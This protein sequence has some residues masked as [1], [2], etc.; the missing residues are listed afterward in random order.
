[1][2][3][4]APWTLPVAWWV[5]LLPLTTLDWRSSTAHVSGRCCLQSERLVWVSPTRHL[6]TIR[7][8]LWECRLPRLSIML[9]RRMRRTMILIPCLLAAIRSL[10][11]SIFW[12]SERF[13]SWRNWTVWIVW[14]VRWRRTGSIQWTILLTSCRFVEDCSICV[15]VESFIFFSAMALEFLSKKKWNPSNI[16]VF[17]QWK[18][19]HQ[20]REQVWL[21]EQ[22]LEKEKKK[23]EELK[24]QLQEERKQDEL[25]RIRDGVSPEEEAVC[26]D[27]YGWLFRR[28]DEW[29]GC[30]RCP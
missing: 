16:K 3:R 13:V 2:T 26:M 1:M 4:C 7:S 10:V 18:T 28:S 19:Q 5:V 20:N 8:R 23:V 11:W 12:C 14:Q 30:M 22:A 25:R 29:N 6:L 21:R 9:T 27:E 15:F 24:R 17:L